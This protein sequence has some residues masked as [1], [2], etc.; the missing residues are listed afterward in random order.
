MKN[1]LDA[2]LRLLISIVMIFITLGP[3]LAYQHIWFALIWFIFPGSLAMVTM[4]YVTENKLL[5]N[6]G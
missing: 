2:I 6:N 4:D 5:K 1:F 3:P